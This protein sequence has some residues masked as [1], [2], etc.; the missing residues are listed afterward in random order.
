MPDTYTCGLNYQ[1]PAKGH[2]RHIFVDLD[3]TLIHY[4]ELADEVYTG[5]YVTYGL[6]GR[7]MFLRPEAHRLLQ[8]CR[9]WADKVVMCTYAAD[10]YACLANEAF[11]LGFG[12]DEMITVELLSTAKDALGPEGLLIDNL[13]VNDE[14]TVIKMHVLGIEAGSLI[15]VPEF[16][17]PEFVELASFLDEL[18]ALLDEALIAGEGQG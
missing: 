7:L 8:I 13:P 4:S 16:V 14:N 12:K 10:V 5:P 18:P 17:H 1:I 3:E 6:Q 2:R 11:D 15:Q 9:Q